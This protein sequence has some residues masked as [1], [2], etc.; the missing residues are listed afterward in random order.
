MYTGLCLS[1]C[2]RDIVDGLVPLKKVDKIIAGTA[3]PTPE[4]WDEVIRSYRKVCW[5]VK[6][7]ECERLARHLIATGMVEQPR[8]QGKEAHIIDDGYWLLNGK[9]IIL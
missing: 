9:K 6:A 1:L 5:S 7:E 4:A 2:V 8:L 3:A